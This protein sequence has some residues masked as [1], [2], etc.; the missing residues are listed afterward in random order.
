MACRALRTA[1]RVPEVLHGWPLTD[2]KGVRHGV[3]MEAEGCTVRPEPSVLGA[4]PERR[5]ASKMPGSVCDETMPDFRAGCK[6][7]NMPS[8]ND[9]GQH[10]PIKLPTQTRED[11]LKVMKGEPL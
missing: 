10:Y 7:D 3:T 9:L 4:L 1:L 6:Q 8:Y 5:S 2:G 11:P